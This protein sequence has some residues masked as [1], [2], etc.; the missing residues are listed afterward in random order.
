MLEIHQMATQL[1]LGFKWPVKQVWDF[2]DIDTDKY[3]GS[4]EMNMV[5]AVKW[6]KD[7]YAVMEKHN[8]N[9]VVGKVSYDRY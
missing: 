1:V 4:W 7:N 5:E 6:C 2:Y 9:K 3:I 8:K